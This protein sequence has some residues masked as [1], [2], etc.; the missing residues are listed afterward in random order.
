[1]TIKAINNIIGL[2]GL[3]STLLVFDLVKYKD[4]RKKE[5][6]GLTVKDIFKI[7]SISDIPSGI[8]IFKSYFINEIKNI[9]TNSEFLKLQLVI[10][11]YNDIEKNYCFDII[12]N[13]SMIVLMYSSF[14][15]S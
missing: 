7:I 9:G 8:Y 11:V 15:S 14:I 3:I 6:D 4:S 12:I 1:M 5:I 10:Q 13:Y 2:N